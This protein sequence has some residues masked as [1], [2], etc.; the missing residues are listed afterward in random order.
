[1]HK[2][3]KRLRILRKR[4]ALEPNFI[5]LKWIIDWKRLDY[6]INKEKWKWFK[7]I[8]RNFREIKWTFRK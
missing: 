7:R 2:I 8:K 6:L 3:N 5:T 4:I 1:M